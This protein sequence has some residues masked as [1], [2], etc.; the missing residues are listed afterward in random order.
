MPKSAV[1]IKKFSQPKWSTYSPEKPPMVLGSNT[2]M[3]EKSAYCVAVY[4]V[5][6]KP[7]K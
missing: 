5:L 6:V 2:I 4:C 1:A 3:D 7:D